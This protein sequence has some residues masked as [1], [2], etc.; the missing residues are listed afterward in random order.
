MCETCQLCYHAPAVWMSGQAV[1]FCALGVRFRPSVCKQRGIFIF[2]T[3]CA[4][5]FTDRG[6]RYN[7]KG[8][9][10]NEKDSVVV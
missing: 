8:K 9:G 2:K 6:S 4:F 1:G 7:Q 10:V 5:M 3:G